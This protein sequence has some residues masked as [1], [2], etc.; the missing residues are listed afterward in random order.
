M[1]A[2]LL[3]LTSPATYNILRDVLLSKKPYLQAE[4]V[5]RTGASPS[6]VSRVTRWLMERGHAERMTDGRYRVR[7]PATVVVSAFPYQRAMSRC[8]VASMN[9]RGTK[10]QVKT[11]VVKAHGILCLESAL[12]DYSQ[13]FRADRV[14]VYHSDPEILIDQLSPIEGGIIPVSVYLPDIPLE[15]DLDRNRRTSKFRTVLDL[16]CSNKVYAAKDLLE[17]IW[18]VVIE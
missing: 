1:T 6:Q 2:S 10:R 16:T 9:I 5:E 13:Y 7:A 12:E 14:C 17:E 15:G 3:S 4:L 18:G 8:L 11:L